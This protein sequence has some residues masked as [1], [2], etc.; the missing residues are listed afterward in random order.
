MNRVSKL[1]IATLSVAA[2]SLW[3]SIAQAASFDCAKA[4]T[5]I[6]H[7]ICANPKLSKLDEEL[8]KAYAAAT[9]QTSE[10]RRNSIRSQ[11]RRWLGDRDKCT[12]DACLIREY[13]QRIAALNARP[14]Y[15]PAAH[16][17][18]SHRILGRYTASPVNLGI[19]AGGYVPLYSA[20]RPLAANFNQFR[21]VPFDS[22]NPRLSPK[23]PRF[24][25]PHWTPMAWNRKLAQR[26]GGMGPCLANDPS[27]EPAWHWWLK[28]TKPLREAG[29]TLLW[30]TTV[31]LLGNGQH[32]TIIRLDHIL[33]YNIVR[34]RF[35]PPAAIPPYSPYLDDKLYMLPS[36]NPQLAEVFNVLF[37][38]GWQIG[39][40]QGNF[41]WPTDIIEN[42]RDKKHPYYVLSWLRAGHRGDGL[43]GVGVIIPPP[44]PQFHGYMSRPLCT[45]KW[46]ATDGS[47]AQ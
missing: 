41:P 20:C 10:E 1:L 38:W 2:G 8:A 21:D 31:D 28:K 23:Y 11:E 39:S 13:K 17:P 32:E 47:H 15:A 24:R 16:F 40:K 44:L 29:K 7:Q 5:K 30:R 34:G 26:V 36:P 27:C 35:V 33:P 9:K 4:H 14:A 22:K 12:N 43:I 37:S 19:N 18:S 3:L 25:R 45:I 46:I 42:A 6:E